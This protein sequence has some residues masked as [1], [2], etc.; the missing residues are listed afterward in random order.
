MG[1][2]ATAGMVTDDSEIFGLDN[3]ESEVVG[4]AC[5]GRLEVYYVLPQH[6]TDRYREREL[7]ICME[8]SL[9]ELGK[10]S[11]DFKEPLC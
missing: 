9:S 5:T 6:H 8:Q 3:L 2:G 7:T 1:S 11:S 4:G 10:N